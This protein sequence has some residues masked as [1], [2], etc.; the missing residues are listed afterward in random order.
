MSQHSIAIS[1]GLKMGKQPPGWWFFATPLKNVKVSWD[2][3]IPNIWKNNNMFQ[4][5]NQMMILCWI[6][7]NTQL[8]DK[9]Q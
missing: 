5:T 7:R 2:D 6:F 9:P 3:E 1:M 4:A 8:L